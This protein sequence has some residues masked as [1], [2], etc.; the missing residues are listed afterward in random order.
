MALNINNFVVERPLRGAMMNTDTGDMMW[1]ITQIENPS[2]KCSGETKDAV[3]AIGNPI[4][5]FNTS[6]KAEFTATNS[7]F[8]LSLASAQFGTTKVDASEGATIIATKFEEFTLADSQTELTLAKVPYGTAGAE[9]KKI[10]S[11]NSDNSKNKSFSLGTTTATATTFLLDATS[12]KI[13]LPTGLTAGTVIFIQY[14]YAAVSGSKITNS[15]ANFP[16]AGKFILEVMGADVC[17]P[18]K[19]YYAYVIF[20]N[21]TL[22]S[23]VDI[24]FSTDSKH[25][26]TIKCNQFYCDAQKKLFD[27]IIAE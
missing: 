26:L 1:T 4:M 2:I 27:I 22:T 8:D 25:A 11:L 24:T 6:K 9:I 15:A 12:K 10:F 3:D 7:L 16:T 14:E 19:K 20:P 18:S 5:T 13:T 21:S 23:D 17:N